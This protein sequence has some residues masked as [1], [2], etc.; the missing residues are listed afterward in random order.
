MNCT[1]CGPITSTSGHYSDCPQQPADPGGAPPG[2][3]P[4]R[5]GHRVTEHIYDA[6]DRPLVT[7][8]SAELSAMVVEAVNSRDDELFT[9]M[10]D[11]FLEGFE[12]GR[13]SRDAEV[14]NLRLDFERLGRAA[15]STCE[16][17]CAAIEQIAQLRLDLECE[18]ERVISAESQLAPI[19]AAIDLYRAQDPEWAAS[20]TYTINSTSIDGV[21][22]P[23]LLQ[24]QIGY[25]VR[26][27]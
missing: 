19:R 12:A 10:L 1:Y 5:V 2:A 25:E 17:N 13:S 22:G 11:R 21:L 7:M 3:L 26:R 15:Q 6:D 27:K 16:N 24:M 8:P 14:E 18:H 23:A 9:T 4:W 20:T